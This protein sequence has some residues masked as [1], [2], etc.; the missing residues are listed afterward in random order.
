MPSLLDRI[1]ELSGLPLTDARPLSG[2][3]QGGATLAASPAGPVVVKVQ[4]DP[5]KAARLL[6]AAPIV[7][8]SQSRWP[9]ARWLAAAPLPCGAFYLQEYVPGTSLDTAEASNVEA[10]IAAN[11]RQ[12][13]LG[14]GEL[15]DHSAQVVAV[16]SGQHAWFEDVARRSRIGAAFAERALALVASAGATSLP[17]NDI[18]HGDLSASNIIINRH[19]DAR[20]I[21]SES[22][23]CG[24]RALDLADL[25]R[26]CATGGYA[27]AST[28][29]RLA[30]AGVRSAGVPRFITCVVGA[31]LNNLAWHAVN[32]ALDEY[33]WMCS[34]AQRVL[35]RIQD[36]CA[37]TGAP[38][39]SR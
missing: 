9:I 4:R 37:D 15:F 20:F 5:T 1:V 11:A 2:G 26:Q 16:T 34:R 27:P 24:H 31:T 6:A 35:D 39:S 14:N 23:G 17:N 7:M 32:R 36:D 28:L 13:G 38:A 8:A 33:E 29:N 3:E 30:A 22:V 25:Y 21:D 10:V 12:Y 19:G 18:V